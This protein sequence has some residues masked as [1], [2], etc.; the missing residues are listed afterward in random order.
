MATRKTKVVAARVPIDLANAIKAEAGRRQQT[1]NEMLTAGF[2]AMYRV[3]NKVL[4]TVPKNDDANPSGD[5]VQWG[6]S[7]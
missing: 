6:Q 7:K 5:P 1:V 2:E 4:E 3:G